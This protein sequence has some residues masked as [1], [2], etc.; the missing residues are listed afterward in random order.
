MWVHSWIVRVFCI[1]CRKHLINI[2]I[3]KKFSFIL[4]LRF[5]F[6]FNYL[7]IYET[8]SHNVAQPHLS[9]SPQCRPQVCN[10]SW[11]L[12]LTYFLFLNDILWDMDF[13]VLFWRSLDYIFLWLFQLLVSFLREHCQVQDHNSPFLCF[14]K[15]FGDTSSYQ[16][17]N[18]L[19]SH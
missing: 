10:S 17:R 19:W 13:F 16:A 7:F 5:Y 6:I 12:C 9:P 18:V 15:E 14:L 8:G 11:L 2:V 4:W 1:L 3:Y